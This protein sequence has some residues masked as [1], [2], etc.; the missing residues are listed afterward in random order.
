M[1]NTKPVTRLELI[2]SY[3]WELINLLKLQMPNPGCFVGLLMYHH[4][5]ENSVSSAT[6][7]S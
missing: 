5:V 4:L 6:I 2:A 3:S 1:K 7:K